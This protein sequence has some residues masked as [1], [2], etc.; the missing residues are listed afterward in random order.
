MAIHRSSDPLREVVARISSIWD[1][2]LM[3]FS[4]S[5]VL[6]SGIQ[7]S[8]DRLREVIERMLSIGPNFLMSFSRS[9]VFAS[10]NPEIV[11]SSKGGGREN[12]VHFGC[13]F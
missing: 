8:S 9:M 11:R 2:F 3:R 7:R 6:L 5:I 13:I 12:V 4:R 10:G 1:A